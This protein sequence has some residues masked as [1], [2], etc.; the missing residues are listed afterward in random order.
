MLANIR[1]YNNNYTCMPVYMYA[2]IHV[3]VDL[4]VNVISSINVCVCVCNVF[5]LCG[6]CI[7]VINTIKLVVG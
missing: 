2:C 7:A 1:L 3:C 4:A 5:W 6:D